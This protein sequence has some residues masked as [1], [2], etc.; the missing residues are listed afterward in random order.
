MI[1]VEDRDHGRLDDGVTMLGELLE[2]LGA[3]D[4][5]VLGGHQPTP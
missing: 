5:Y 1:G 2:S 4:L 3:L